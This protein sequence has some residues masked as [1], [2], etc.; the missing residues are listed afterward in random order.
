M[1]DIGAAPDPA[2]SS[3][4]R[5][6]ESPFLTRLLRSRNRRMVAGESAGRAGMDISI[7]FKNNSNDLNNA[8]IVIFQKNVAL[9][10]NATVAW[11]VI[12]HC[13]PGES[14]AFTFPAEMSVRATDGYGNLSADLPARPGHV[15][16]VSR[17]ADGDTLRP[18]G[19]G[20]TDDKV[21]V[22]N[23]LL[24]E[25]VDVHIYR[26]GKLLATH[27]SLPPD[28]TAAFQFMPELWI[29]VATQ[30]EEGQVMTEA[31]LAQMTANVS[32]NGLASADLAMS[33]A[34][35][36]AASKPYAFTLENVVP[37]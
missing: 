12:Q 17:E 21:Q 24:S 25:H 16:A 37:A 10:A 4:E 27:A 8:K 7:T 15:F 2:K 5:P 29:G 26:G 18:A 1:S 20:D 6:L 3:F 23:Q 34:G 36:G 19:I 31:M 33:G 30:V 14:H 11:R 32:L 13:D 35:L 22:S 9:P 28:G